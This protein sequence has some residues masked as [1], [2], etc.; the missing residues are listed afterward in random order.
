VRALADG[1]RVDPD[2]RASR[3]PATVNR[4]HPRGLR[5]SDHD[6]VRVDVA[7]AG[8]DDQPFTP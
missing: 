7:P 5:L 8:Q 3:A 6:P 4:P 1:E 2:G